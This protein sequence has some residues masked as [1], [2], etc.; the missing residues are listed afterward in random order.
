M[1][2][3]RESLSK[4][5][6]LARRQPRLG[7]F[8]AG[9]TPEQELLL[10]TVDVLYNRMGLPLDIFAKQLGVQSQ[11]VRL[12]RRRKGNIPSKKVVERI[13]DLYADNM[14]SGDGKCQ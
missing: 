12:W 7:R 3:T 4:K 11:T 9:F 2:L 5:F 10:Y 14:G 1:Y 6:H 8:E 13:L